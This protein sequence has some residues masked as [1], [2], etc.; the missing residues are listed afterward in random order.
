M[1]K[2]KIPQWRMKKQGCGGRASMVYGFTI[3][4]AIG[5]LSP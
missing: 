5:T 2:K 1:K 3:T 4:H